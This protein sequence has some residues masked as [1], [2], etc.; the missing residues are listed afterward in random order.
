MLLEVK[1][2]EQ[3]EEKAVSYFQRTANHYQ[4]EGKFWFG[5]CLIEGK[6]IRKSY[7][8]GLELIYQANDENYFIADLYSSLVQSFR[9]K[10]K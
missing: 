3:D 1:F 7:Y 10:F 5:F 8:R 4:V 6:G 2:I 9:S